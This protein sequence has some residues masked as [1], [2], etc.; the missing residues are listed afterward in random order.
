MPPQRSSG[1]PRIGKRQIARDYLSARQWTAIGKAEWEQLRRDLPSISENSLREAL[2]ESPVAV[3][4]PYRGI[5]SKSLED[6]EMSLLDMQRVYAANRELSAICRRVVIQAKDRARF[7]ARNP[8]ID[9]SKREM[10]EEMLRWMLV[11]LEDPSMFEPWVRL[12]KKCLHLREV[13]CSTIA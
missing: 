9:A 11:W 1:I 3:E 7:A 10:K 5:R 8:K 2:R 6:L 13:P 12:R 4:Q